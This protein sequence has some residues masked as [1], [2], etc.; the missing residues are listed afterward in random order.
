MRHPY[1]L[2][3]KN[4]LYTIL[5]AAIVMVFLDQCI[6]ESCA[7]DLPT[8]KLVY[9]RSIDDLPLYVGVEKGF[10]KEAGINLELEYISGEPNTLAA[11]MRGDVSGGY[12]SLSSLIKLAEEKAP[13]KVVSW[14]GHAHKGTKCG[15][16]VGSQTKYKTL[17]DLKGIRIATSGSLMVKTLLTHAVYLGGYTLKDIRPMW[18]GTPENPMQHEAAL[19]SGGIDGFIV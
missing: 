17:E 2:F 9:W 3:I 11:V 1:H 6:S 15:I 4:V 13:I 5:M 10:F 12:I 14:M 7:E 16:H 19:R 8:V 18:G